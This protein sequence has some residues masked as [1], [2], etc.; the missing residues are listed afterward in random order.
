MKRI[1]QHS[2]ALTFCLAFLTAHAQ[3]GGRGPSGPDFSGAMS[4][5]FGENTAF[6][7]DVEL[8]AVGGDQGDMTMPGKISYL[9][10]KSRFELDLAEMKGANLPP[11]AVDQMKQMG[12]DKMT[13]ISVPDQKLVY[14]VYPGL[15]SYAATT[16]SNTESATAGTNP[17]VQITELGK[18]QVDGHDCVKNKATVKDKD[19][20]T[21]EFTVWNATDLKKFPVKIVTAQQGMDITMVFKNVKFS[22]PDAALFNPPAGYTKYDSAMELMQKEMTRRMS[23]STNTPR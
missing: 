21:T 14:L 13:T 5:L 17:D 3:F 2:L 8:Q 9:E 22:K 15:K 6:T 23:E 7:S 19:G 18:E 4:K 20:K 12:M 16:V 1:L 11:Q 10:G